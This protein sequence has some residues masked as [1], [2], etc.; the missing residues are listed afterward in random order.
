MSSKREIYEWAGVV[1]L[2]S[3]SAIPLLAGLH[4]LWLIETGSRLTENSRFLNEPLPAIVHILS[5]AIYGPL[6][7]TQFSLHLRDRWRRHHRKIGTTLV[8]TGLGVTLSG[9]WMTQFYPRVGHD[10]PA[11]YR[12]RMLA[13]GGV[14]ISLATALFCLRRQEFERHGQWML[15]AYALAMGAGTQVFTHIPLFLFPQLQGELGRAVAMG[16]AW[17]LNC[18]LVEW[19]INKNSKRLKAGGP[20]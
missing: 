18:A 19:F 11:V 13:G 1:V 6:G 17:F 14:L 2:W 20:S 9:L 4:R 3:L 7:A 15:R 5:F 8:A 12:L 10:G 16:S